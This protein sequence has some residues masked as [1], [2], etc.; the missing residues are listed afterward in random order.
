MRSSNLCTTD[1]ELS[2]TP[3]VRLGTAGPICR[4]PSADSSPQHLNRCHCHAA[5]CACSYAACGA[6][7]ARGIE[8]SSGYCGVLGKRSRATHRKPAQTQTDLAL[9]LSNNR[10]SALPH[11]S[12]IAAAAL[13]PAAAAAAPAVR[14]MPGPLL[15]AVLPPPPLALAPAAVAVRICRDAPRQAGGQ[16]WRQLLD[17][18]HCL[19]LLTQNL[20]RQWFVGPSASVRTCT[21]PRSGACGASSCASCAASL[22][23]SSSSPSYASC[24]PPCRRRRPPPPALIGRGVRPGHQQGGG[25]FECSAAGPAARLA[26]D[27]QLR[28]RAALRTPLSTP[29]PAPHRRL[30]L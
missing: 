16:A 7:A 1:L 4:H 28:H 8:A 20:S 21:H 5:S 15:V 17:A 23:L 29:R 9:G 14:V 10:P 13:I 3:T 22:S 2:S 19:G 30:Q 18:S 6:S 25:R 26:C 12:A 11:L 24:P 27:G